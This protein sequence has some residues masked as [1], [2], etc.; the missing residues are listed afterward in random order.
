MRLSVYGKSN[1][2]TLGS[3]PSVQQIQDFFVSL[4]ANTGTVVK[5][6]LRCKHMSNMSKQF[7]TP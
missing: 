7:D 3:L 1:K 2:K 4:K 6:S 5:L